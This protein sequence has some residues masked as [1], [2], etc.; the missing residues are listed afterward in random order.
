MLF[1][2]TYKQRNFMATLAYLLK[3]VY[4]ENRYMLAF[5]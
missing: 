1:K 3:D 2:K 5:N 4:L